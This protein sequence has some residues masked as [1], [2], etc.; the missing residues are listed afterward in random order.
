[1]LNN[2]VLQANIGGTLSFTVTNVPYAAYS[3]VVYDLASSAGVVQ[4]ITAGGVSFFTLSPFPRTAGY[5]D[6]D[7]A[8][9]FTYTQG[10]GLSAATATAN[11]DYV[12]FPLLTGS[13]LTISAVTTSGSAQIAGFQI[14]N[15]PEPR[16]YALALVGGAG[17]LGAVRRSRRA[18]A[19]R[20]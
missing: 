19:G 17:L 16:T 12:L 2:G 10:T 20:V 5:I 6:N 3:V 7:P 18:A 11:A 14:I 8:T 9:P 15:V 13:T 4:S 1:M